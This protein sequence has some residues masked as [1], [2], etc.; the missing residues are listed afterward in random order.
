MSERTQDSSPRHEVHNHLAAILGFARLCLDADAD[1]RR[2]D[3]TH[4]E[5]IERAA[6]AAAAALRADADGS[7]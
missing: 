2:P 4:L 7:V 1:G 3:R 5:C 6:E